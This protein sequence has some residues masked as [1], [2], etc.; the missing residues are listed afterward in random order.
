L[1]SLY[2]LHIPYT[3]PPPSAIYSLSLTRRSSDLEAIT[4]LMTLL[5]LKRAGVTL[6]RDVIFLATADEEVGAGVGAAWMVEHHPR[7]PDARDRKSTRL[8]SSH[9]TISYAVFCL[10]KKNRVPNR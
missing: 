5:T 6:K 3:A 8:N 9:R 1:T 7:R 10:K 2:L 4:Q